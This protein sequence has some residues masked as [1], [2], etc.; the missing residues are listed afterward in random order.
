MAEPLK[1][2]LGNTDLSRSVAEVPDIALV[3]RYFE[4]EPTNQEDQVDLLARPGLKKWKEIGV[5]P[6]RQVYS[7]PGAFDNALFAVSGADVYRI[8][9]DETETVIGTLTSSTGAVSMTAT[10][11]PHNLY[12]ADGAKLW[13]YYVNSY[14]TG[15][16]TTTA[17]F[18]ANDV[19]RIGSVYYQFTSGSVDTGSP[20]GTSGNPWL[21]KLGGSTQIS[22]DNL[23]DAINGIGTAG[24]TYSTVLVSNPEAYASQKTAPTLE[25]RA[26]EAGVAGNSIATTETSANASWGAATLADGGASGFEEVAVPDD[27]GIISVGYIAG[28]VICVVVQSSDK[29]GRFYWIRPGEVTIDALDY[30]TAERSPDPV[31]E[32]MVVGD[33][34]WLP[35]S[36]TNEV[37][38]PTG[39]GDLPFVRQQGRLFDK[40]IWEGTIVQVKDEVMAVGTDGTVY[41]IGAAPEVVST[42]G[43]AQRI[44]EAIQLQ[45]AT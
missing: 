43:I 13:R 28:F 23:Y 25:V 35:G 12:I 30:A 29:R 11:F 18:V 8:D 15:V 42:P 5:G 41:R 45:R 20:A 39:D 6:I 44:R 22:L 27:D 33:Q 34:F 4:E 32:V 19:V 14:A 16:L 40:G 3:N 10:E 24:L 21:V 36:S 7:Q 17:N 2:P 1:V 31:W 38:Y 9:T 26:L 37:W